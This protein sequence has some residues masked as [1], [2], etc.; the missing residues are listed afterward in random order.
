MTSKTLTCQ[1]VVDSQVKWVAENFDYVFDGISTFEAIDAPNV[2]EFSHGLIVGGSGSGKST[3]LKAFGAEILPSWQKNKAIISHFNDPAFGAEALMGA[4]LSSIPAWVKPY[5][6]LSTGEK[7]RADLAFRLDNFA[8]IDEF[9]S[10]VDRDVA[11]SACVGAS[12]RIE[13]MK[14]RGVVFASCHRDIISW[15][16]PEWVLDMDTG[17]LSRRV[18]RR[19][20]IQIDIFPATA[21]DWNTFKKH[22]YLDGAIN[23]SAKFF[24]A[25]WGDRCVAFAATLPL[26][27]GTLQNAWREH[28]LVVLPEFQGLGIGPRIS[29]SIAQLHKDNGKRF[30]SKTAHL[31]LGEYR[32]QSALWRGTSKNKKKRSDYDDMSKHGNKHSESLLKKHE[33]RV[34]FS[35]EYIGE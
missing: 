22:H 31:R 1:V 9:T 19:P 8:V 23:K 32:E 34:C 26:P 30:F 2:G 16:S 33:H 17:Q 18:D 6:V 13:K 12:R 27:S 29:D 24:I 10:V 14:L 28:R 11:K 5:D 35:H 25:Y 7:F 15:L 20:K 4:G 21:S 3:L